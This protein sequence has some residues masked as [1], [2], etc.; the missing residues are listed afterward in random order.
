MMRLIGFLES[1]ESRQTDLQILEVILELADGD[2]EAAD[3][4]WRE[5]D[6]MELI[7]VFVM[8]AQR[9]LNP[10]TLKW[11]PLGFLWSRAL[12]ELE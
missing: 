6:N 2:E 1:A 7:D 10:E 8:L 4:I 5:P 12:Q 3:R 9:G 11:A